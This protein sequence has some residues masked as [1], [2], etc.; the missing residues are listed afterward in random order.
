MTLIRDYHAEYLHRNPGK[1]D[2][3]HYRAYQRAYYRAHRAE[4]DAMS[5]PRMKAWRARKARQEAF[6]A[7]WLDYA[8]R[9]EYAWRCKRLRQ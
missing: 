3:E 5:V 7:Q 6:V 8:E 9:Y 2:R 4:R 1:R